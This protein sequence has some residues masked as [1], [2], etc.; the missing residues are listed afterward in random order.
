MKHTILL[1]SSA[2]LLA[3]TA[4]NRQEATTPGANQVKTYSTSNVMHNAARF[5]GTGY[6]QSIPI[7]TAN[8]MIGSYLSSVGYPYADTTI[9]SLSFNADTLRA[10]L[11][12]SNIKDVKF[13]MAHQI[14]WLDADMNRYGKN[15]GLAPGKLTLIVVG[16]DNDGNVVRNSANGVYEHCMPCPMNCGSGSAD[17]YLQ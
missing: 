5:E 8:K 10:Y 4:C 11:N 14:T 1:A 7:D 16:L 6:S 12:N 15:I 3:F 13:Y 17:P 2:L 9:R